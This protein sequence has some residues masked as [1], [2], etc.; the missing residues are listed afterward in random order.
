MFYQKKQIDKK[1]NCPNCTVRF[2]VPRLLPCG[3]IICESCLISIRNKNDMYKIRCPLCPE[4][5]E[6]P[7]NDFPVCQ[8]ILELLE[9]NP[10]EV[11]RGKSA[12]IL[13]TELNQIQNNLN[14]LG[15]FF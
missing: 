3:K 8:L 11:Y 15:I 13:K 5:H 2:D 12:E 9:E 7:K 6:I 4:T 1:L 10:C 14:E